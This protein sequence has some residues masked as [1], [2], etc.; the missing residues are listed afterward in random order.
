MDDVKNSQP[1]GC[2]DAH[3]HVWTPDLAR[4]PLAARYSSRDMEPASFTADEMLSVARPAGVDRVVLI[5]MIFYG[6]DNSYMLDCLRDYPGVFSGVAQIDAYGADPAEEMAR[7]RK[8]GVRG[9]RIAPPK[10]G[11]AEWLDGA[12]MHA[13]WKCGAQSAMAICPLIDVDDLPAVDRMC[14]KFP[15]T[16]VVFDHCARIGGDGQI[17]ECDLALLCQ[18]AR[19]SSTRVK[20]SAFYFL[21]GKQ[22]PYVDLAPMIRRLCDAFGPERLMW[23]SDC[24][25][26]VQPPH[27]YEASLNLIRHH[28][29]FL[30]DSDKQ[31]ILRRT[32]E[33]MFFAETG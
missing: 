21:G 22:P 4:Y 9:V 18:L 23:A 7:L 8:L 32:A 24:P 6:F 11:A 10:H 12:G 5:Q 13:M 3:A 17:R 27:T 19:H 1:N 29:D 33:S 2:I 28:L 15:E 26:Q 25:F 31:W 16:P 14:Q 20:L 30:S